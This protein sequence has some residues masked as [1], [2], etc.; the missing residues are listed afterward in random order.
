[1][2]DDTMGG[3]LDE[4]EV[5]AVATEVID[6]TLQTDQIQYEQGVDP[7]KETPWDPAPAREKIRGWI[8]LILIWLLVG[9]VVLSFVSLWANWIAMP[10]LE[11]LLGLLFGPIVALVGAATGFYYGG[12]DSS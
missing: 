8:A 6:L 11:G 12:R 5:P 1:M 10:D 7:R 9:T 2:T 3:G 4:P